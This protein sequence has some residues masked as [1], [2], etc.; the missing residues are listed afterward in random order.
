MHP[1]RQNRTL[2]ACAVLFLAASLSFGDSH[3]IPADF[4]SWHKWLENCRPDSFAAIQ[5]KID[6][7]FAATPPDRHSDPA[8]GRYTRK[9]LHRSGLFA[10]V[11]KT[12]EWMEME[13]RAVGVGWTWLLNSENQRCER[14]AREERK[15]IAR[16]SR[17][18][19]ERRQRMERE[20]AEQA[21][22][23]R[24]AIEGEERKAA[25]RRNRIRV[26]MAEQARKEREAARKAAACAEHAQYKETLAQ[27]P[28]LNIPRFTMT[29]IRQWEAWMQ[30]NYPIR[31][32]RYDNQLTVFLECELKAYEEQGKV[33]D[34]VLELAESAGAFAFIVQTKEWDHY[35][36]W[37]DRQPR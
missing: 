7:I 13:S 1:N 8:K 9:Y 27:G 3:W 19:A 34:S 35:L 18:D 4:R 12:P 22:M 29:D 16:R 30:D 25:E 32:A 21:R 6:A 33:M 15:R 37:L 36:S 26:E 17:E 2:M 28:M 20:L 24:E 5:P 31:F 10:F 11:T 23:E 14:E